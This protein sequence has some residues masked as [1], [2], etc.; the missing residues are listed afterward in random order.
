[1]KKSPFLQY[2]VEHVKGDDKWSLDACFG[3]ALESG[4]FR[5]EEVVC[6]KTLYNYVDLG[7][8]PIKNMDLPEKTSRNTKT[9]AVR[10]NKRELGRSVEERSENV[11]NREEF[12]HW[13]ADTV[14]GKKD[15]NEPCVLVMTERQTRDSIWVKAPSHTADALNEAIKAVMSFFSEKRSEVFKTITV[16]NGS[17]FANLPIL[18]D[19][20]LKVYFTHPYSSFEKGTV[21]CHNRMLR[22]FIP[23]GKSIADYTDEQI[24]FFADC[25][26]GLPRKILSYR[27]PTEL[28]DAQLDAL[29]AV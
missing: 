8:L 22:R 16:D 27:S 23:K 1:M 28:F 21:E 3:A 29:Y 24:C 10:K 7:I 5:R 17:E 14:I 26:N 15:E 25:I 20:N 2:V 4:A 19:D 6:A 13:E 9:K 12:G 11:D 18:E